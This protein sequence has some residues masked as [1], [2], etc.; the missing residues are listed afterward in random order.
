MQEIISLKPILTLPFF[1]SLVLLIIQNHKTLQFIYHH[2]MNVYFTYD[3]KQSS[4][5]VFTKR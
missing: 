3:Q 1:L 5:F 2:Y 4:V